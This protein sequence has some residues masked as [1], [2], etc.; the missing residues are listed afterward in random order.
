MTDLA[1]HTS[2]LPDEPRRSIVGDLRTIAVREIWRYRELLYQ[3]ALRDIRI[4]YK[5][6]VMGFAWAVLMPALIVGAGVLIRFAMAYVSGSAVERG[7]ILGMA[8]KALPWAFF[9]GAVG[10]ATTSLTGNFEMVTKVAFPRLVLPLSAVA[11]QAFDTAVGAAALVL[12]TPLLG[13]QPSA[14]WL[15]APLLVAQAV[16]I[17]AAASVL[18]SCAN[19][20][21]R[22]VKYLVQVILTFGIFF[23]PV[24]FEPA[25]FGAVGGKLIMLNPLAPVLEGLRLAVVVGHDLAEPLRIV[26]AR[27]VAVLAWTPWYLAYA[28][29]VAVLGLAGSLLLFRRLE[30]VFAEYA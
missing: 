3:L 9:V 24:F 25:M 22:D 13:L 30:H 23:T 20:F 4:R 14:A 19:L 28:G 5:Q 7:A 26:D 16:A 18:L 10:F 11:T 21:F 27:G 6:A 15:W 2:R 12:V 8:V 29:A 17:T 1:I